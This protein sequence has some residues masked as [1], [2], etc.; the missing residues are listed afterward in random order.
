MSLFGGGG[1]VWAA[2]LGALVIGSIANGMDLRGR[3]SDVK[4]LITGGALLATVSLD[5][6]TASRAGRFTPVPSHDDLWAAARRSCGH[7]GGGEAGRQVPAPHLGSDHVGRGRGVR[8]KQLLDVER[9]WRDMKSTLELRPGFHRIEDRIRA[10]VILCR[11]AL[12]CIGVAETKTG[13][14]WRTLHHELDR[15]HVGEFT[16]NSGRVLHRTEL[17][18]RQLAILRMLGVDTPPRFLD[19]DP[20]T[21]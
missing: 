14:T 11:L 7:G 1:T 8:E 3:E 10:H 15:L 19:V 9:G 17:T 5:A 16:G 18:S 20:A 6:I 2:L 12:L 13:D 4:F 21:G